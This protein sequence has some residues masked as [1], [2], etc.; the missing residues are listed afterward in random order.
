[1]K[2]E[3]AN[4]KKANDKDEDQFVLRLP[5]ELS[6]QMRLALASKAKRDAAGAETKF[7]VQFVTERHALFTV[8]DKRYPGTLY[9]MPTIVET[10][11]T[12]DKRTYY[13]S[14][15]VHQ[16]LI[17]SLPA[18][19]DDAEHPKIVPD[20]SPI[21][22]LPYLL[23]DGIARAATGAAKRFYVPP[24]AF[25]ADQVS[26]VENQMKYVSDN[27]LA[28]VKKKTPAKP[29]AAEEQDDVIIEEEADP[30]PAVPT[31]VKPPVVQ[32]P[33]VPA[34]SAP[35]TP[36]PTTPAPEAPPAPAPP[37]PAPAAAEEYN[38]LDEFAEMLGDTLKTDT[39]TA[40]AP[41]S[42]AAGGVGTGT[43]E[44]EADRAKIRLMRTKLDG[45][46]EDTK[47]KIQSIRDDAAKM[48][49]PVLKK[50]ILAK[51]PE[52]ETQL[53]KLEEERGKLD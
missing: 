6:E 42:S 24:T 33:T 28:F 18:L 3:K 11:K 7:S 12:A 1:M 5:P 50:R 29:A 34:S 20:N 10:H 27:K 4:D 38:E 40:A 30:V 43:G 44:T 22:Q 45:E 2:K 26:S 21:P 17:V 13:K 23:G 15:D 53:Q 14:G 31:P 46:I 9:D 8:N 52:M 47:G 39:V 41:A 25:S 37:A 19:E 48:P 35:T 16:V 51:V 49:N 32:L 36:A